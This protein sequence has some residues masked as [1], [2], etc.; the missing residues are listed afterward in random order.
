M[1]S[2]FK[3]F[4]FK[5][6]VV[7]LATGV[8]IGTAF[9]KIVTAFTEGFVN[10]LL[11]LLGGSP[12]VAMKIQI[13]G[14]TG[15]KEGVYLDVGL[16]ISAIISFL[17]TAAIIFFFIVKP[18]NALQK[19]MAEDEVKAPPKPSDEVVLLGEIRDALKK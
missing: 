9:G 14:E 2:E 8:I 12:E 19:R 6:D 10:P 17:I 5:G 4:I 3:K 15:A 18:A 13:A 7:A 16:I 1:L 11:K